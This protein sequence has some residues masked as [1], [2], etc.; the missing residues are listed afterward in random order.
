M[1]GYL[2]ISMNTSRVYFR[3]E[4]VSGFYRV[5][6]FFIAKVFTDMLPMRMVPLVF[7]VVITYFMVGEL[8]V[9]IAD[10]HV[11][12]KDTGGV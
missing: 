5:S 11:L 6:A 12:M 9:L 8:T 1:H 3:H 4:N 7:Y 10:T 2:Q